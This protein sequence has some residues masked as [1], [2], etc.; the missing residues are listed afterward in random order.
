MSESLKPLPLRA[1][2]PLF[3]LPGAMFFLLYYLWF[4]QLVAAGW[5][6]WTAFY[7]VTIGGFSSLIVVATIM[8]RI[9]RPVWSVGD[10][11]VRP[12]LTRISRR[13]RLLVVFGIVVSIGG[14]VG[15]LFTARMV[16]ALFGRLPLWYMQP[17]VSIVG[18][19]GLIVARIVLVL[20]NV[21]GE[22]L[23]WRGVVL[24]R[25]EQT[26]GPHTWW[27]HGLQWLAFHWWKPWEVV[28]LLPS[29]LVY[30]WIACRTR[31]TTPALVMHACLNGLGIVT[32]TIAVVS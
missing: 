22:E 29:C 31:S 18:R 14:Y 24:P 27:V 32:V 12:R 13:D 6:Y 8:L 19:Y 11:R 26:H 2:T 23:L 7:L 21:I 3:L 5:F 1:S 9:E 15:F 28:M 10:L 17:D 4:P 16:Y 30:G 25:Q 20:V